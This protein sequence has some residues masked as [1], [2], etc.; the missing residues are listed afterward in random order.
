[1]GA[2]DVTFTGRVIEDVAAYFQLG[3]VFVL[4]GLGGLAISEAMAHGLPIVCSEAD[5]CELDLV[6]PGAN[7][8]IF[9][10]GDGRA[11]EQTLDA[12]VGDRE[13]LRAMGERSRWIIEH[14][15]NIHT[16]MENLR[17]ALRFAHTGQRRTEPPA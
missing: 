5:G 11:L 13:R 17:D 8:D 12:M 9:E 16:Y 3:D 6:E 1:M 15:F 7:G 14:R 2:S 4:P 10:V